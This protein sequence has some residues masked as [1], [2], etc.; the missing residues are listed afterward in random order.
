MAKGDTKRKVY[1]VNLHILNIAYFCPRF[2]S[3]LGNADLVFCD[4]F[5]VLLA[6]YLLGK[7]LYHR[8]TVPD[9]IDGLAEVAGSEKVSF[10]YLV[11]KRA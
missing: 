5:G 7:R 1:H 10:F 11:T 4:G 2:R 6:L 3:S 8:N 9:W